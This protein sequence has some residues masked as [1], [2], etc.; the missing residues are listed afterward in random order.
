MERERERTIERGNHH[1]RYRYRENGR[2]RRGAGPFFDPFLYVMLMMLRGDEEKRGKSLYGHRNLHVITNF[3]GEIIVTCR[4]IRNS[5]I[6]QLPKNSFFSYHHFHTFT[7]I[8]QQAD[9]RKA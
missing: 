1:Y 3:T 8:R 5:F 2:M 6:N 4:K 7:W 9:Y